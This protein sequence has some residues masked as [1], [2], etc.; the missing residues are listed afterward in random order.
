MRITCAALVGFWL[1]AGL[2]GS[3]RAQRAV[4]TLSSVF[5]AGPSQQSATVLYLNPGDTLDLLAPTPT[6]H[7]YHGRLS[8]GPEGWVYANRVQVI[9]SSVSTSTVVTA[10]VSPL[11][12][13]DS[14]KAWSKPRPVEL[15]TG[16]CV[17]V[18]KGK[19]GAHV[20]SAT[21]L[22][23]NRVDVPAAY[24]AVP[25]AAILAL[26]W[27][28][29]PRRRYSWTTAD[30]AA[31]AE[32]E[33]API[34]IEGYLGGAR[35]EQEE[36]TNCELTTSDWHDWHVWLVPTDTAGKAGDRRNAV[37]VETTPRVRATHP[38]WA[39]DSLLAAHTQGRRVRISGWL[40]FDPDHPDQVG[41][42]RGTTWEIHPI[43][44]IE[45]WG[46]GGGTWMDLDLAH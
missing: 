5:H 25:I 22:R 37:V 24:H 4:V 32:H 19:N 10:S 1:A 17:A 8:G 36:A 2:A 18:G 12:W 38:R 14:I 46:G 13:G 27:Q 9:T 11:Q 40:M 3:L 29:L 44:R 33:G 34:M 30:S 42:T 41:N 39:I 31:V 26:P 15:D 35:E 21:N 23:K 43:T 28:G 16:A 6:N 20:D 45:L 7:Y